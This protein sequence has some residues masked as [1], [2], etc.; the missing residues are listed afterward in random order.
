MGDGASIGAG[1]HAERSPFGL[2]VQ[3]AHCQREG[4]RRTRFNRSKR[5]QLA[6]YVVGAANNLIRM[7]RCSQRPHDGTFMERVPMRPSFHFMLVQ[8]VSEFER[9]ER[10]N[11]AVVAAREDS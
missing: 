2:D 11:A 7:A 6:A 10:Q 1:G 8:L 9:L 3:V 5:T 4:F